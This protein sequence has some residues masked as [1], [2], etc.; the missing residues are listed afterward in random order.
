MNKC[1]E[2]SL[3]KG[4]KGLSA[5][6]MDIQP[7]ITLSLHDDNLKSLLDSLE[8]LIDT[9]G[10]FSIPIAFTEQVPEKLGVTLS[11][12]S[13]R[14]PNSKVIQK[15]TFS[16]FGNN[17]FCDWLE[18][19]D[20]NHLLLSGIETSICVYLTAIDAL[21]RGIGVTV[22]SDCILSRNENDS[23]FALKELSKAGASILS[24]E[25]ILYSLLGSSNHPEFKTVSNMV[26]SRGKK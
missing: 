23:R 11:S 2:L 20:C 22:L 7:K 18:N 17:V 8:L 4:A 12:L 26:K 16:A 3:L 24:L 9:M 10:C 19:N 14:L 5:I 1:E 6:V 21:R 25:T 15:N 13:S